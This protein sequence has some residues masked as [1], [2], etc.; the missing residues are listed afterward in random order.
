MMMML[1]GEIVHFDESDKMI[2]ISVKVG[3]SNTMTKFISL[4]TFSFN[5]ILL[6]INNEILPLNPV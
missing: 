3:K 4:L 5:K 1:Y 2:K 6:L